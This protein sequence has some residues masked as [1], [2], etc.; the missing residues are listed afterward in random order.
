MLATRAAVLVDAGER[1][2]ARQ[3]LGALNSGLIVELE[4]I[5]LDERTYIWGSLGEE[6]REVGLTT[7]QVMSKGLARTSGGRTLYRA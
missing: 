6:P 5:C 7:F 4:E 3:R 1:A 2:L